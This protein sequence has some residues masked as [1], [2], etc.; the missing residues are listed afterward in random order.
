MQGYDLIMLAI[1]AGTTIFGAYKGMAWQ[2]AAIASLGASY[3][4][5]Y[6]FSDYLVGTGWF[7]TTAPWNRFAA[8]L[9]LYLLSGVLIWFAFQ[10]IRETIER[11]KLK[12]FDH[13]LG[14]LF[15][16]VKGVLFC[17]V[18][19]FFVVTLAPDHMRDQVI[20][21]HSGR[22]MAKLLHRAETVMPNEVLTV[23]KPYIDQFEA[24]LAQPSNHNGNLPPTIPL[25]PDELGN[26]SVPTTAQPIP[27]PNQNQPWPS[28]GPT[29]ESYPVPNQ[30]PT[31]PTQ[32]NP[33]PQPW[34]NPGTGY[35]APQQ[36]PP[37][38]YFPA[39]PQ[40]YQP[41]YPSWP[42]RPEQGP[43]Y[44]SESSLQRWSEQR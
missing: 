5:S 12:D 38:P 31:W 6:F 25:L 37:Q 3:F 21:T 11:V 2:L 41:T 44:P 28:R 7:G 1:L 24:E 18:I 42:N 32:P 30:Q 35:P 9:V 19:T 20:N 43:A 26:W 40:S 39:Y 23:L 33:V 34:M 16:F 14:G 10:L 29:N 8:M 17:M 13:Q 22:V 15:G 36:Q 4:A 27:T